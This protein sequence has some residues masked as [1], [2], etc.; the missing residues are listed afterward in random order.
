MKRAFMIPL[1]IAVAMMSSCTY[2]YPNYENKSFWD[3]F[4]QPKATSL[5]IGENLKIVLPQSGKP[6]NNTAII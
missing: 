3:C 1:I 4:C 2:S 6:F 5:N